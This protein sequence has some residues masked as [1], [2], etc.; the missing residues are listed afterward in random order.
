M[1]LWYHF[2]NSSELDLTLKKRRGKIKGRDF[3]G[4][5]LVLKTC[6][7][8]LDTNHTKTPKILGK[9]MV[10]LKD[11]LKQENLRCYFR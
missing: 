11:T 7:Q 5:K 2:N 9:P 8:N 6:L 3:Y 4:Q 1:V 10:G